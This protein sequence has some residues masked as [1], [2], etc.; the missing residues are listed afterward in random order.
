MYSANVTYQR[1]ETA[2]KWAVHP[3]FYKLQKSYALVQGIMC[4][5]Q[6]AGPFETCLNKAHNTGSVDDRISDTFSVQSGLKHQRVY[7]YCFSILIPSMPLGIC[8]NTDRA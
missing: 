8:K 5:L 3:I 2:I 6:L 4:T 1:K 7:N